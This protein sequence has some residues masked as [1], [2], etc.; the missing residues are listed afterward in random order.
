MLVVIASRFGMPVST[1][2]VSVGSIFGIGMANGGV[3]KRVAYGIVM[4]WTGTLPL[5]A[6]LAALVFGMLQILSL[7]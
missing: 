6:L 1:T 2:H 3:D 4:A 5:S 7:N